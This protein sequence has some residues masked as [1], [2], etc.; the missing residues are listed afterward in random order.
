[1]SGTQ[2]NF[3]CPSQGDVEFLTATMEKA[4]GYITA[5][6]R[7]LS[8]SVMFSPKSIVSRLFRKGRFRKETLQ[9]RERHE[10]AIDCFTL[11]QAIV[12]VCSAQRRLFAALHL[13]FQND[14]DVK[15][16]SE[17]LSVAEKLLAEAQSRVD[18]HKSDEIDHIPSALRQSLR[19]LRE[20][21]QGTVKVDIAVATLLGT[22]AK[23]E[24][25][26]PSEVPDN[27]APTTS[28]TPQPDHGKV[29]IG[30]ARF[31]VSEEGVISDMTNGLQWV[32]GPDIRTTYDGAEEWVKECRIAG[33]GWR[34]PTRAELRCLRVTNKEAGNIDPVFKTTGYTIW[35]EPKE[36]GE[37]YGR[38]GWC[39]YFANGREELVSTSHFE[40]GTRAFGVRPAPQPQAAQ[41]LTP[42]SP[43]DITAIVPDL[44]LFVAEQ[45]KNEKD[46]ALRLR[47]EDYRQIFQEMAHLPVQSG[48]ALPAKAYER[49]AATAEK[50]VAN[51]VYHVAQS[52]AQGSTLK[53]ERVEPGLLRVQAGSADF[54][55]E[56]NGS[57]DFRSWWF[58]GSDTNA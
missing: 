10:L 48:R 7:P 30:H 12:A 58:D 20:D 22:L 43:N 29:P 37:G 19:P 56:R 9:Y 47:R 5:T 42:S 23:L 34:M 26:A 52:I 51:T 35:A 45:W 41:L 8:L 46:P 21:Q 24:K 11:A 40:E 44:L 13:R 50:L 25:P 33:G 53:I 3:K 2:G 28:S 31:S 39:L 16:A 18:A 55:I 36:A 6:G 54:R 4:R 27:A 38:R 57:N 49:P 14:P 1:M 32:V 17:A 15:P